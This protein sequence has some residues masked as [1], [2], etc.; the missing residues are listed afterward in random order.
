MSQIKPFVKADNYSGK[1]DVRINIIS[2]DIMKCPKKMSDRLDFSDWTEDFDLIGYDEDNEKIYH[3]LKF[4]CETGGSQNRSLKL[5]TNM[6]YYTAKNIEKFG[7][8]K[9]KFVFITDGKFLMDFADPIEGHDVSRLHYQIDRVNPKYR[10]YF[11]IG[12]TKRYVE[13]LRKKK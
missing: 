2:Y 10:K 12:S 3:N 11:F 1:T 4:I 13:Y 8:D 6:I 5:L 7:A 9:K